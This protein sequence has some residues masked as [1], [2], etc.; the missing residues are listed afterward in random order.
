MISD[1]SEV[2]TKYLLASTEDMLNKQGI[3]IFSFLFKKDFEAGLKNNKLKYDERDDFFAEKRRG[4]QMCI[5]NLTGGSKE[6][7]SVFTMRKETG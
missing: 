4:L 1:Y 6:E 7:N 5:Q 3:N 2:L